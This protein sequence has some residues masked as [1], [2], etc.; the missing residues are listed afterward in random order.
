MDNVVSLV[1]CPVCFDSYSEENAPTTLPCGHTFCIPCYNDMLLRQMKSFV[2]PTCNT[3]PASPV[4]RKNGS[5]PFNRPMKNI[6]LVDANE[7]I[8][9]LSA[10][11]G[12]LQEQTRNMEAVI[13]DLEARVAVFT[14]SSTGPH[15]SG[16]K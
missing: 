3:N 4:L 8:G 5:L 15:T 9:V 10:K 11:V 7:K 6:S 14:R 16:S 1:E 2:C 12:R 13:A